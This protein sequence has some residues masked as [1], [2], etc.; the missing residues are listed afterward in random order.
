MSGI[1]IDFKIVS[2]DGYTDI[3]PVITKTEDAAPA[4][5][6]PSYMSPYVGKSQDGDFY[7][8]GVAVQHPGD[9][10]PTITVLKKIP[11][12]DIGEKGI[13]ISGSGVTLG[14][15]SFHQL[16][17][18]H[19]PKRSD[20]TGEEIIDTAKSINI[21]GTDGNDQVVIRGD[22]GKTKVEVK[23]GKGDDTF[24]SEKSAVGTAIVD[25]G[26]GNDSLWTLSGSKVNISR[27]A[28]ATI[29]SVPE[30]LR[31]SDQFEYIK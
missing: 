30:E 21:I 3:S 6:V 14:N 12:Q 24:I 5:S 28:M 18:E 19:K 16:D 20:D 22:L 2:K 27:P 15:V 8:I 23:L 4:K 25:F 26:E 11:V 10:E 13:Q 29:D 9:Y 7:D 17:A 1:N 31:S